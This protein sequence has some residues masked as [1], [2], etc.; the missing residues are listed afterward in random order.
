LIPLAWKKKHLTKR[1]NT[2]SNRWKSNIS[3][4]SRNR[5][6][7]CRWSSSIKIAAASPFLP[8]FYN[9]W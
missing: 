1:S 8:F 6:N 2:S 9:L 4:G 7:S 5:R 3:T